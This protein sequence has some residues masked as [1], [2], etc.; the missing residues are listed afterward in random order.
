MLFSFLLGIDPG[1]KRGK[2]PSEKAE[3]TV[4]GKPLVKPEDLEIIKIGSPL[5]TVRTLRRPTNPPGHFFTSSS[6]IGMHDT[7]D[8]ASSEQ[9]GEK[10]DKTPGMS[11]SVRDVLENMFPHHF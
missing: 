6:I 2:P 8:A 1:G 9:M 11:L 7:A 3:P 4:V 10:K 5:K